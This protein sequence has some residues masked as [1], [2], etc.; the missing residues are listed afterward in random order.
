MTPK[1]PPPGLEAA[2]HALRPLLLE[3]LRARDIPADFAQEFPALRFMQ[4]GGAAPSA[5]RFTAPRRIDVVGSFLLG[6]YT[7]EELTVDV[8][9]EMPSDIFRSKDY[10]NFR[11]HDKRAAYLAELHRQLCDGL[12][13]GPIQR[14]S[15][16]GCGCSLEHS[17]PVDV[18][19]PKFIFLFATDPPNVVEHYDDC[20]AAMQSRFPESDMIVFELPGFGM[21]HS[22]RASMD[23]LACDLT[24]FVKKVKCEF[25]SESGLVLVM[26]CVSALFSPVLLRDLPQ[27]TVEHLVVVQCADY[28]GELS[29]ANGV[30]ARGMLSLPILARLYN[31]LNAKAISANWY[32]A[33]FPKRGSYLE[34]SGCRGSRAL[35]AEGSLEHGADEARTW[36]SSVAGKAFDAGARFPLAWCLQQLFYAPPRECKLVG[37][38]REGAATIKTSTLVV[39]GMQDATHRGNFQRELEAPSF[40]RYVSGGVEESAH[41]PELQHPQRFAT[42]VFDFL[43]ESAGK[44]STLS[45]AV[46]IRIDQSMKFWAMAVRSEPLV[47]LSASFE[48]LAGDPLRPCLC[49]QPEDD[50]RWTIRLLP[51]YSADLWPVRVLGTEMLSAPTGLWRMAECQPPPTTTA[52]N[53][54]NAMKGV[55]SIETEGFLL[56]MLAAHAANT[57]GVAPMQ[58]SSFQLFKLTLSVLATT[59]WKEQKVTFGVAGAAKLSSAEAQVANAHFYDAD[60]MP[61]AKTEQKAG[62]VGGTRPPHDTQV[63]VEEGMEKRKETN[64]KKKK[65]REEL[66]EAEHFVTF[67]RKGGDLVQRFFCDIGINKCCAEGAVNFLSRVGPVVEELQWEAKRALRAM[68]SQADPFEMVFGCQATPELAWDL[69]LR[70][71]QLPSTAMCPDLRTETPAGEVPASF[72]AD[73]PEALATAEHL[74]SVL[75]AGLDDRCVRSALRWVGH[76]QPRW[77]ER[78]PETGPAVLVGLILAPENLERLVDR[79]PSAQDAAATKFRQLWGTEKSELRRFKDGSIL[80]CVVWQK[81]PAERTMETR[82]QPAVVTQIVQHLLT[83]HLPSQLAPKTDI[84][85]GP[86]GFVPNLAE[87]DRRLWAAFETFRTHL[88]QLSSLPLAVKDIHPVDAS[89]SY[90][91]I[92]STIAPPAPSGSDAKLRRTLLETVLEFESSGRWPSEP[93]PA[94]KV[95]AA[96]LLQIREELSTDLGIEADATEGF[97]DVRYPETVFRLRIFHPHELQEVANKVTGL[98]AQTTAA[99]GEAE[100]ERLRTLWWRPRLRAS[101]HAHALQKP[102]MAGAARLFKRWMASQ[103]MSG[104]DEFCEHLVSAVFLHPAPFG[105]PSSPHVGFCRALWLLDTFDWQREAL[106]I[107]IDGKLTEEERLGLRQSFENRLDAAQKDASLI[108]FWVSTRLDPHALLL[109]TP[110]STV[111]GWLRRRAQEAL[112]SFHARLLGLEGS[113]RQV[114]ELDTSAFDVVLQ[115]LP[116]LEVG[117]APAVTQNGDEGKRETLQIVSAEAADALV[118]GLREKLSPVCLVFHD[119]QQQVVALKWRPSAFLPQP[120][121]ALMGSVPHTVIPQGPGEPPLC[122]PNVLC[123]LATV[124]AMAEASG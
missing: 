63:A 72:P 99:P 53:W 36:F 101:L 31:Y 108:R 103:M 33:T 8:A 95:G 43:Q 121:N 76:L 52:A 69:C 113:W 124:S 75:R 77:T 120:Q 28:A 118:Q 89:F 24:E 115:L 65:D 41:F 12:L 96:L 82:K 122:V 23:D 105:A 47:A 109:A 114:F 71:P 110:P 73:M 45:H 19:I 30:N 107:D 37:L 102:A 27:G 29:W 60:T 49:L 22:A 48:A 104:Y 9:V 1:K 42:A 64:A 85:S 81:P 18:L 112:R 92:Q 98:Q 59:E 67:V 26:P 2:L 5:L 10:L 17:K 56:S 94:Q 39:W 13:R 117:G 90:M 123:I 100:L 80:E 50:A 35:D 44:E 88:C 106:I 38:L 25:A 116:P 16:N 3:K 97:L 54:R 55:E 34:C 84:I 58:T 32:K 91:S 93:A 40:S 83:R 70:L 4:R 21:S 68:D 14:I 62:P 111:A 119:A 51:T 46:R 87:K 78:P 86:T 66:L 7:K 61:K 6:T 15:G 74:R 20:F 11:Y 57:A 79:G